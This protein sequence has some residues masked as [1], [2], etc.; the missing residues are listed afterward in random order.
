V[1]ERNVVLVCAWAR[2]RPRNNRQCVRDDAF[3]AAP[4]SQL[5]L[6]KAPCDEAFATAGHENSVANLAQV[7]L[8]TDRVFKDGA[9]ADDDR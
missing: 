2:T 6:P 9:D 4:A 1:R 3:K 8:S 7:T 5:A